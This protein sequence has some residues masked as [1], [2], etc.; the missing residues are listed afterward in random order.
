[1]R[2]GDFFKT[3]WL[4]EL[5]KIIIYLHS[6]G[7]QPN[8]TIHASSC[9]PLL[10]VSVHTYSHTVGQQIL[11]NGPSALPPPSNCIPS[12]VRANTEDTRSLSGNDTRL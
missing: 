11:D 6:P 2:E 12:Q 8:Q 3:K 4:R 9:L 1:M 5:K 10:T 7:L